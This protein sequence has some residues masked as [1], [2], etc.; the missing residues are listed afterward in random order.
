MEKRLE[1]LPEK[2]RALVHKQGQTAGSRKGHKFIRWSVYPKPIR[3]VKAFAEGEEKREKSVR[4]SRASLAVLEASF[5]QCK[6][7]SLVRSTAEPKYRS[8]ITTFTVEHA[9]IQACALMHFY[10]ALLGPNSL[11]TTTPVTNA[12]DVAASFALVTPSTIRRWRKDFEGNGNRFTESLLGKSIHSWIMDDPTICR[13]AKRYLKR[14][15]LRR[16]TKKEAVFQIRDFQTFLNDTL[17]P[18]HGVKPWNGA[19]SSK[20]KSVEK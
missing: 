19:P 18:R 13:S 7:A 3:Q 15:V 11:K 16:A 10:K 6:F 14:A 8:H 4:N 2:W 5:S 12:E 20:V 9:A 1:V 17:L